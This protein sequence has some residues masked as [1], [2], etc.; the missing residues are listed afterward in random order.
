MNPQRAKMDKTRRELH[1]PG[2]AGE[3]NEVV[4]DVGSRSL[5]ESGGGT[6]GNAL[7]VGGV[8]AILAATLWPFTFEFHRLTWV[9]Y[10]SSFELA[11]STVL[12]WPRNILLF[13]PFGFGLASLHDRR[14]RS[15]RAA[16]LLALLTGF[17]VT[18]C[19]E[20]LQIFL[21]NRTANVSDMIA[22]TLGAAAGLVCFRA[23]QGRQALSR[24]AR[25]RLVPRNIAVVFGVYSFLVL[26]LV[27]ALMRGM[28]PGGW[29]TTYR[30]ALG[31]EVTKDRPWRGTIRDLVVL[32]RAVD[33]AAATQL[34]SGEMPPDLADAVVAEYTLRGETGLQDQR[35]GLPDLVLQTTEMPEF[36]PNGVALEKGSWLATE[37]SVRPLADRIN[38]SRQF[39]VAVT[40]ETRDLTQTGPARIVTVSKDPFH[41]NLTL[42]QDGTSLALRWRSPLTGENGTTPEL[43]FPGVFSSLEPQRVVITC[44]GIR[45]RLYTI[46]GKADRSVFLGPEVGFAAVLR[47]SSYWP[48]QAGRSAFWQSALLLSALIFLPLGLLLGTSVA[49]AERRRNRTSLIVGGLFLPVLL[50][51][52]FIAWHR[53]CGLRLEMIALDI[54]ATSLG[55]VAIY[56]WRRHAQGSLNPVNGLNSD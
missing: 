12:D 15:P 3:L 26:F 34:L 48:V 31:N 42:G 41:R 39:T 9:E 56:L 43:Q 30:L 19:I 16:L 23:W 32:D 17:L 13:V 37:S 47:E 44:D 29:D 27:W 52:G 11:P 36:R 6:V 33:K 1:G 35:R 4:L 40:A 53:S 51:E 50:L 54:A 25:A 22:N 49:V 18:A 20:S 5:R 45:A 55:Y 14:G 28:L 21:P 46:G 8:V 2:P 38:T 10:V 7:L 24:L